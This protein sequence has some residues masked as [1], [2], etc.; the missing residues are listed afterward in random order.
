VDWVF[1]FSVDGTS[2][3]DWITNDVHDSAQSLRADWNTDWSTGIDDFLASDETLSGIHGNGSD[4]GVSQM[5]G[6][7]E[8]KSVFDSFDFEG[9]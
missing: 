9:I 2:F 5:L 3:I 4:S 6:H 1:Y 8:N 7:F